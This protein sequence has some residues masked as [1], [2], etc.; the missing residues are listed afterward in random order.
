MRWRVVI[1]MSVILGPM[2]SPSKEPSPGCVPVAPTS[3]LHAALESSLK[4]VRGWVADGDFDSAEQTAQ[5][6]AA[7]AWLQ[8]FQGSE[9]PWRQKT[10]ALREAC[11]G[12]SIALRR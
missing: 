6:L 8:G 12:L 7:L 10:S 2:A 3:A 4:Q 11:K 9:G 1:L 5:G